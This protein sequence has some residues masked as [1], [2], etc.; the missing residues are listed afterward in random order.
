MFCLKY[1]LFN[2]YGLRY[3]NAQEYD[4]IDQEYVTSMIIFI[5]KYVDVHI[6]FN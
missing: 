1:N 2:L 3:W 5:G 4:I 6:G